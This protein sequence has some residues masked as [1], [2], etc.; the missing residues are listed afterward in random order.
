MEGYREQISPKLAL[1]RSRIFPKEYRK[2]IAG[3]ESCMVEIG[4][5][6]VLQGG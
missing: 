3:L 6:N 2:E 1:V 5:V 4:N